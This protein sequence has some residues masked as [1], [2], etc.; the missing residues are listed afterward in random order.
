MNADMHPITLTQLRDY[1]AGDPEL[2]TVVEYATLADPLLVAKL[3]DLILGFMAFIPF[4]TLSDRAYVWVHLT[5]T[6]NCHKTTIGKLARRW[7]PIIHSRYRQLFSHC[8]TRPE[9][10]AWV[11]FVGGQC[12][13]E[14]N[15]LVRFTIEDR[16]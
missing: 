3:G 16:V 8:T 6:G 12:V 4:S 5:P 11:R 13:D 15:G 10:L 14:T 2:D 1:L 9:H 7:K